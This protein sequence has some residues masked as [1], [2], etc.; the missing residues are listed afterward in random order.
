[1]TVVAVAALL[2]CCPSWLRAQEAD[3]SPEALRGL[4]GIAVLVHPL[5]EKLHMAGLREARLRGISE[6]GLK[7]AGIRVLHEGEDVPAGVPAI[8]ITLTGVRE[9]QGTFYVFDLDFRLRRGS[10]VRRGQ[11]EGPDAGWR[12]RWNGMVAVNRLDQVDGQLRVLLGEF[13]SVYRS[14]NR[15]R[16]KTAPE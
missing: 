14:V 9:P 8:E 2:L 10:L 11:A 5:G 16:P 1:M 7:E 3:A 15:P 13:A 12:R 6:A 4:D